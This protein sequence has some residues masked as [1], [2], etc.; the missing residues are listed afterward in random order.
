MDR[1]RQY[2]SRNDGNVLFRKFSFFFYFFSN[3]EPT[4]KNKK[5]KKTK[6]S[7]SAREMPSMNDDLACSIF[8][9]DYYFH[10]HL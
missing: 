2:S 8:T 3:K 9:I 7:P 4:K 1:G 10:Y 6:R 5:Q